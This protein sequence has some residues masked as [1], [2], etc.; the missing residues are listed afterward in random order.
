MR[1]LT[2][3]PIRGLRNVHV[4]EAQDHVLNYVTGVEELNQLQRDSGLRWDEPHLVQQRLVLGNR[5]KR[6]ISELRQHQQPPVVAEQPLYNE[7][8]E[9]NVNWFIKLKRYIVAYIICFL[10]WVLQKLIMHL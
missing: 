6:A 3:C 2:R 4:E 5:L 7:V 9:R 8:V 10:Y 1:I